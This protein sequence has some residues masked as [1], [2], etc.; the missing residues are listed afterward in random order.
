M[1]ITVNKQSYNTFGGSN[2]Y[3]PIGDLLICNIHD[4]GPAIQSLDI[5]V[6]LP[7]RERIFLP[8]LE[9]IFDRFHSY[10]ETLPKGTF[11]RGKNRVEIIFRSHRLFAED[12]VDLRP[13]L[14]LLRSAA[15]DVADSLGI[16]QSKIK[17]TDSFD[18]K[19]FLADAIPSL[20]NLPETLE[21]WAE[22]RDRAKAIRLLALASKDPWEQL[23]VD[24]TRYHPEARKILDDPF[25]WEGADDTA[26][27]GNDTGADLLDDYLRWS[28]RNKAG[29]PLT[30]LAKLLKGWGIRQM[31]WMLV[32][33]EET[34]KQHLE[35]PIA[36]PVCNESVIAL[37]FATLKIHAECPP[38]LI[39]MALA[40]LTRTETLIAD[41]KLSDSIQAEWH[42]S[43]GKMRRKLESLLPKV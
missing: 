17:A 31:D 3:S 13:S 42:Q 8:T 21:A 33:P 28:K 6:C 9:E 1:D 41:S 20:K 14:E 25:F 43:I 34:R 32:D 27:H 11:R 7:S 38:D 5:T 36:L 16:L 15:A 39:R 26:P 29:S 2:L 19:R 30:F 10:L 18:L 40:S 22:M 35:N 24:W 37:A 23:D 12:D 4:Y